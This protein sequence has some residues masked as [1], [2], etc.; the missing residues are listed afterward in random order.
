MFLTV[1]ALAKKKSK[2]ILV[3]MVSEAGTGFS[4][5]TRR[6][7]LEDKLTLLRY[8]PSVKKQVLFKEKKKIR[9]I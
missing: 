9:S 4:F 8:D 2:Y 3:R 6:L 7:R 1:A 5:N